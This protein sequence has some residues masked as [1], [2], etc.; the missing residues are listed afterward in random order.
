M[1]LLHN[2]GTLPLAVASLRSVA[3]IGPNADAVSIMGG[4][5]AEVTPYPSATPLEALREAFG[6]DVLVT[7][8]RG[9]DIDRSPRP[10]GSVG[11]RAVD[12]F[13]VELFGG[14]E[15]DGVVVDRWQTERLR[16]FHFGVPHPGVEE[17]KWSMRVQGGVVTEETGVFTF[18][19]AQ[20][21][22]ARVLVDGNVVLDG[23]ASP[24]PPGGTEFFGFASQELT[25][26]VP[27][28]SGV[29]LE[30]VLELVP[31][32][33]GSPGARVGFRAPEPPDLLDRA[34]AA[35]ASADVAIVVVGTTREWESEGHDR[36]GFALPGRQAEL[37]QRVAAT[38]RP[39][40]VVVNAGAPVDLGCCDAVAATLQCW[41][42]GQDT[43]RALADVVVGAVEPAGR[44]PTT[45]PMRIEHNPSYDNFPGENGELRYGEGVF[46]GYRGYEHRAIAPRF[47]F[48]HGL[49]YTTFEFGEP[50]CSAATFTPG[51]SVTVSVPVTNTG[52]QAGAAV[53]QCYVAPESPRLARPPKE[54]KAFAKVSVEAGR[55]ETVDL[56]LDDRSF[57]YWDP[58]QP[59]WQVDAGRYS[60]LIGRS[61]TDITGRCTIDVADNVTIGS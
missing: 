54:L 44:L 36:A 24:P 31:A 38:G 21:G 29:P 61:A 56:V 45:I 34:V 28:Q 51:Q 42:G 8:E 59:G 35:A 13:T 3:V 14:P 12:G 20:V 57:A 52:A 2:D 23:I 39:T 11:L 40:V 15:L 58:G 26:E 10:V 41:F 7:H 6:P 9:C 27:V 25:A 32:G 1:V 43:G 19:L 33:S 37:I 55:T 22:G 17:G 18:A 16:L 46:T 60:I 49:G 48:G 47:P 4:G 5:S 50:T 30:V 53:V